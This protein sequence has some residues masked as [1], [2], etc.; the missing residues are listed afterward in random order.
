MQD[1]IVTIDCAKTPNALGISERFTANTAGLREDDTVFSVSKLFHSYGFGNAMTFPPWV[2]ATIAL[3]DELVSPE[4][5]E[6][7]VIGTVWV[8]GE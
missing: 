3:S 4:I 8:K 7:G 1:N 5:T 2:G 6:P